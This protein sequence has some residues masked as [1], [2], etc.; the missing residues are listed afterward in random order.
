[1][2]LW[3]S[4]IIKT[5]WLLKCNVFT[6]TVMFTDIKYFFQLTTGNVS[7]GNVNNIQTSTSMRTDLYPQMPILR[8]HAARYSTNGASVA[9]C[10]HAG[11]RG[12]HAGRF[13]AFGGAKFTKICD[14]LPWTAM[15]HCAKCDTASLIFGGVT[16]QTKKQTHKQ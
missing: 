3:A 2:F 10:L 13:W 14:S 5:V 6:I 12:L 1:M 11:G 16:V 7:N 8:P 4:M 15:N 9:W